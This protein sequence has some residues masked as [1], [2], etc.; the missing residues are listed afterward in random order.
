MQLKKKALILSYN[1]F[2]KGDAGA[3]RQEAF[4]KMLHDI[5]Y[6]V[7]VL[8]MGQYTGAISIKCE[9]YSYMSM[10]NKKSDFLSRLNNFFGY[11]KKLNEFLSSNQNW[12]LIFVVDLPINAMNVALQ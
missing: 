9:K 4:A 7:F 5:G 10:R 6:N 3:I 2:P 12:D 8:G 11:A 1:R